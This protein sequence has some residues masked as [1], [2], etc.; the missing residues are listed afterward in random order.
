MVEGG[1]P[2]RSFPNDI[3]GADAIVLE[4]NEQRLTEPNHLT[5]F[6]HDALAAIPAISPVVRKPPFHYEGRP[7]HRWDVTL[8]LKAPLPPPSRSRR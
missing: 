4:C 6:L 2:P 7:T 1:A 3:L 5:A 8:P